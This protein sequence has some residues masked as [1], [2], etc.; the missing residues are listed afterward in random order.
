MDYSHRL[1]LP[2][3]CVLLLLVAESLL[4]VDV[5]E[6]RD[7]G[8]TLAG[9]D[10]PTLRLLGLVIAGGVG[11]GAQAPGAAFDVGFHGVHLT[12]RH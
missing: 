8:H 5:V 1:R 9:E 7:G 3:A 11:E 4:G 10:D 6:L 2:G 12:V